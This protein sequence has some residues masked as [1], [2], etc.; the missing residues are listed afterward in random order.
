M[1]LRHL[2]VAVLPLDTPSPP[3][4]GPDLSSLSVCLAPGPVR[5]PL[6][7][8]LETKTVSQH[9][10]KHTHR[11]SDLLE[12]AR[13]H[14]VRRPATVRTMRV[15]A[16]EFEASGAAGTPYFAGHAPQGHAHRAAEART[17]PNPTCA[18]IP[19]LTHGPQQEAGSITCK[20]SRA[21]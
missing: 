20:Q 4:P 3:L 7:P 2:L 12:A 14:R 19:A 16:S 8:H 1:R 17:S 6:R 9:F 10:P 21:C 5:P 15:G 11:S 13:V 18:P